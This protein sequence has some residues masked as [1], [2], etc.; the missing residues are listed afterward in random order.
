M[1]EIWR[2]GNVRVSDAKSNGFLSTGFIREGGHNV[3][4]TF[5]SDVLH[6]FL[7]LPLNSENEPVHSVQ[8]TDDMKMLLDRRHRRMTESLSSSSRRRPRVYSHRQRHSLCESESESDDSESE[9]STSVIN[10]LRRGAQRVSERANST[11]FLPPAAPWMYNIGDKVNVETKERLFENGT[12]VSRD[13]NSAGDLVYVVRFPPI[14]DDPDYQR[15][16]TFKDAIP[17][18]NI[19][20]YIAASPNPTSSSSEK[21]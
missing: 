6:N 17:E 16:W 10:I 8:L 9:S 18:H 20:P 5:M 1:E 19:C 4:I 11:R 2:T 3:S 13:V 7:F 14:P 15:E 12:V 21:S